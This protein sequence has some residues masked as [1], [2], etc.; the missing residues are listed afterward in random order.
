MTLTLTGHHRQ[1]PAEDR[2]HLGQ[3][4]GCEGEDRLRRHQGHALVVELVG[5]DQVETGYTF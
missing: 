5:D 4:V 3:V 2:R 1:S